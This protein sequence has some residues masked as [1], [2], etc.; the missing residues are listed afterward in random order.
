MSTRS[1]IAI[2][3][4]DGSVTSIYCHWDGYP[5]NNG[6]ILL[7]HYKDEG[8]VRQLVA[9]G[10]ISSLGPSILPTGKQKHT[11]ESHEPGVVLAYNR[12]CHEDWDY[13]KPNAYKSE[14]DWRLGGLE[15][16]AYL[17]KDGNWYVIDCHC[18]ANERR[19]VPLD[20]KYIEEYQKEFERQCAE[21]EKE[22]KAEAE[23]AK[24]AKKADKEKPG[25]YWK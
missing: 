8:K 18:P 19:I 15:E 13:V 21:Y 12:D 7:E 16:W 10:S 23:K 25:N 4:A 6:R 17:F 3:N 24:K 22:R 1:N 11:K 2:K 5:T 9:L 14:E 20:E